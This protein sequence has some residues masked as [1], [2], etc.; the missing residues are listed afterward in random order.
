MEIGDKI[1]CVNNIFEYDDIFFEDKTITLNKIYTIKNIHNS[2]NLANCIDI[3]YP[4]IISVCIKAKYGYGF[5]ELNNFITL[6]EYRYQQLNKL[7]K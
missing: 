7:L 4:D 2:K 3:Q 1:V 6:T 5:Y